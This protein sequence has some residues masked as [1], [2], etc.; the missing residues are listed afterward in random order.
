M[1]ILYLGEPSPISVWLQQ[2]AVVFQTTKVITMS[3]VSADFI[4]SYGYRHIIPADIIDRF[5]RKAINLHI[6]YL[7]WNRGSDPNMWS[8][9][10]NT[11]KGVTIH[12][13][14]AGIDTGDIIAH[15][16]I[17]FKDDDTLKTSY[18]KLHGSIQQLFEIYWPWVSVGAVIPQPQVGVGSYHRR[19]DKDKILLRNG[20]DTPVRWLESYKAEVD[21]SGEFFK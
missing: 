12:Y 10:D 15:Q 4:I 19:S 2:H 17:H 14:D 5:Y 9:I 11:P 6:S 13:L 1:K 18:D 7:P 16:E 3:S 21:M 8:F 20:W